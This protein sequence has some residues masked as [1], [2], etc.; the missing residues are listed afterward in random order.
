MAKWPKDFAAFAFVHA[1]LIAAA[2]GT[3]CHVRTPSPRLPTNT[4]PARADFCGSL[5]ANS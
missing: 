2:V 5:R 4:D 3:A 1:G